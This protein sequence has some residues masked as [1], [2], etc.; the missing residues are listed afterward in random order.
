MQMSYFFGA[1]S[2]PFPSDFG[3]ETITLFGDVSVNGKQILIFGVT[4]VLMALLQF[5]VRYTKWGNAMRAVAVD[6]QAAQLMGIDVDGVISFT[7]ALGSAL[8]WDCRVCLWGVLQY[9][10]NNNGDYSRTESLRCGRTWW[11]R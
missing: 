3:T 9:H 1:E 6:E 11:Y 2:R 5:I 7:F 10:L 4:V 8:G